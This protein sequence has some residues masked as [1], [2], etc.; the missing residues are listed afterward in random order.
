MD[1]RRLWVEFGAHDFPLLLTGCQLPQGTPGVPV[2]PLWFPLPYTLLL[3]GP[4]APR[5]GRGGGSGGESECAD[6][7]SH[8][9][10]GS[11]GRAAHRGAPG[12]SLGQGLE[13]GIYLLCH[14]CQ[15]KLKLVLG[16]GRGQRVM[17]KPGLCSCP[18]MG[19]AWGQP[20]GGK[21]GSPPGGGLEAGRRGRPL[22]LSLGK[23]RG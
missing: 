5:R 20:L 12:V 6:R 22:P 19:A 10:G 23:G 21:E 13:D 8:R 17:G 18:G 7:C 1:R 16:K 2:C 11:G 3:E 9:Q 4:D 14:S 15:G